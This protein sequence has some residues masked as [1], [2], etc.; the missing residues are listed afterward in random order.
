M[1]ERGRPPKK[2]QN[3]GDAELLDRVYPE[4]LYTVH[5]DE[6]RFFIESR[7]IRVRLRYFSDSGGTTAP[8]TRTTQCWID[9]RPTAKAD[10]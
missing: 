6:L 3:L 2:T 1:I 4:D 7:S 8:Q 9:F 5:Q 10:P